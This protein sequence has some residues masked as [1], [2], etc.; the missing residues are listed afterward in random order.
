VTFIRTE[1]VAV[2]VIAAVANKDK[3]IPPKSLL[4]D[5]RRAFA[6]NLEDRISINSLKR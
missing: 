5:D 6:T 1:F 3:A 2:Y 4:E